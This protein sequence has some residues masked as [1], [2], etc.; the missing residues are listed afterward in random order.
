MDDII[1]GKEIDDSKQLGVFIDPQKLEPEMERIRQE[2][3][4]DPKYLQERREDL[5]KCL[6]ET[7]FEKAYPVPPFQRPATGCVLRMLDKPNTSKLISKCRQE[8]VTV[9]AAISAA[10]E[11]SIVKLLEE[12]N[13][14]KKDKYR[15]S[16]AHTVLNRAFYESKQLE[17]GHGVG[18]FTMHN[19]VPADAMTTFWDFAKCYAIKL[20]NARKQ[21]AN[22]QQ[23][24]I[25]ELTNFSPIVQLD[26]DG[27]GQPCKQMKYYMSANM[28]EVSPFFGDF[29]HVQLEY[30]C[31]FTKIS[32]HNVLWL[33]SSHTLRGEL[34]HSLQFNSHLV[35][36]KTT[37]LLSDT[38]FQTLE[39]VTATW[40]FSHEKI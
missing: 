13:L 35:N 19:D 10:I 11:A 4:R 38:L 37:K 7:D 21:R 12:S 32:L 28:T 25:K 33:S 22:L 3:L 24:V 26:A 14:E 30:F 5:E 8:A 18:H 9:H 39:E 36:E 31:P 29:T 2:F 40:N 1:S 27:Q 15:I 16:S 17:L 6:L 34:V 23:N 20:K